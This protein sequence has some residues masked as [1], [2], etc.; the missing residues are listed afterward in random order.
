MDLGCTLEWLGL[1]CVFGGEFLAASFSIS[2]P[3][4]R[5]WSRYSVSGSVHGPWGLILVKVVWNQVGSGLLSC[6]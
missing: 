3:D 5:C 4:F 2:A 6:S 1:F